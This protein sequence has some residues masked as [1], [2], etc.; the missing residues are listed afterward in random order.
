M[1]FPGRMLA[2]SNGMTIWQ[3]P[4]GPG[5]HLHLVNR[6][7]VIDM[8]AEELAALADVSASAVD[9]SQA[10]EEP[11]DHARRLQILQA[12]VTD[13]V[14]RERGAAVDEPAEGA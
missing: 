11:K 3:R 6:G 14:R 1:I 8:T 7:I 2:N 13:Y 12:R 9:A 5:Y 4:Q 10:T